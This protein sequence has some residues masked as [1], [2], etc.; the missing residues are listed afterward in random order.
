VAVRLD[1]ITAS[2]RRMLAELT[3][4]ISNR[5]AAEFE[6]AAR[7]ESLNVGVT[8]EE[9]GKHGRLEI[10]YALLQE[11]EADLTARDALRVRIKSARD[12]MMFRPPPS[13]P[14][15]DIAPLADPGMWNRGGFG[16]GGGRGRR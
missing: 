11:A 1:T 6:K 2:Q 5:L 8:L 13:R 3:G 9:R 16:R 14:R 15:A 7:P 10:P 4:R 12:R